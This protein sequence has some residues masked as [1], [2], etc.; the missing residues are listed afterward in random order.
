MKLDFPEFVRLFPLRSKRISWLFGAGSSVSA[1]LP[2]AYDL[3]WDFKCR[4]YCS[5]QGLPLSRFSNLSDPGIRIQIQSYFDSNPEFPE[6]DSPEE[7]SFYFEKAFPS[8]SDRKHYLDVLLA[9]MQLSFGHKV[10][11]LLMKKGHISLIFTTNFDKAFENTAV[12]SF[13]NAENWYRTD[14]EDA[15][16]G[17]KL[18]QENKSPLIVK[19][20]GD[21]ISE[22]LKNTKEELRSQD[23][24]LR[25]ILGISSLT[26]GLAIMG[27]S[28][29][30][31]SIVEALYEAIDKDH[32]FPSGIFWF[33]QTGRE[34]LPVVNEFIQAARSKN[35]E[36]YIIEIETFDSAWGD[37]IKGFS[38]ISSTELEALNENYFRRKNAPLPPKGKK[39][40]M[41]RLNAIK[42]TKF[43]ITARLYKCAAGNTKEIKGL[44]E[45][46]KSEILAIRKYQGIVGFG[47]DNEF[48]KAFNRYGHYEL[49]TFEIH[50]KHLGY[51]DSSIKGLM[52]QSIGLALSRNRPLQYVKRGSKHFIIPNQKEKGN[53]IFDQ[54]KSEIGGEIFGKINGTSIGWTPCLEFSLQYKLGNA[55]LLLIPSILASKSDAPHEKKQ[56]APFIKEITARWYNKHFDRLISTWI[57]IIFDGK[58]ETI[59]SSFANDLNGINAS[60]E[61]QSRTAYTKSQ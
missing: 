11:G 54:L 22:K 1:G 28:G 23:Q 57:S 52:T 19:L 27:Y 61:L 26:K 48:K 46:S 10:I 18:F 43:P 32:S 51:D 58:S 12:S 34:V 6:K 44:I 25:Q 56:I 36:A 47:S 5:E 14:L 3:I 4:L 17:L 42:L 45:E 9:G 41:V 24:K 35:I 16:N 40:P 39:A 53:I 37:I 30:D 55:Y 21:Y 50:E 7:Y 13:G 38:D 60:F 20:H 31:E 33:T 15:D 49:D 29:R 8:A 2:S 59:I